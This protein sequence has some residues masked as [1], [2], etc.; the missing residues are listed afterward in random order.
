MYSKSIEPAPP[1]APLSLAA[2][3][4]LIYSTSAYLML[5]G[6]SAMLYAIIAE[7]IERDDAYLL[8]DKIARIEMLLLR[9]D[10]ELLEQEVAWK[11]GVEKMP[12]YSR[13]V[14]R[15]GRLDM[16]TASMAETLPYR[17]FPPPVPEGA[18]ARVTTVQHSKLD[19]G[20]SFGMLSATWRNPLTGDSGL[21]QVGLDDT[22]EDLY[23]A[24]VRAACFLV[25]LFGTLLSAGL[26]HLAARRGLK[27]LRDIAVAAER[28][29]AS[30][31]NERIDPAH[32]PRE[33]GSLALALNRMLGR[34]E[35]AFVRMSQCTAELAHEL[36]TPIHNL[37]GE[38]GVA[39]SAKRK[40]EEYRRVLESSLEEYER[41]SRMINEM[42]F[43]ARAENP[44]QQL[45][46]ERFDARRELEAVREFFDALSEARG[47][48]VTC[49]GSAELEANALL[50]RRALTNLVSNALRHTP[51]GGEV[52]LAVDQPSDVEV[53]VKVSDSGQ[54]IAPEQA[55]RLWDRRYGR[56]R[57][58]S[59]GSNGLG[60]SIVKSIMELHG[61]AITLQS[62]P[63]RGTC[64]QLRFPQ[65]QPTAGAAP[66]TRCA[67]TSLQKL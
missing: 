65:R 60:L 25:L 56:A 23:L 44:K 8:V 14:D 32:W 38:A 24:R 15:E 48:R 43:L 58:A 12:F 37:M 30:Q 54:G 7:G 17:R 2:R 36:R 66:T 59:P 3:L 5:V 41:L 63:G 29:T 61:G 50:F 28:I 31:L 49:R 39:L 64:V 51:R 19:D 42:L 10:R 13:V 67:L 11:G 4:F 20:R 46:R 16:E 33:L 6:A 57:K 1:R 52:V 18:L 9:G 26:G 22:D 40:P 47:I 62:A 34:L 35:E 27:P 21:I 53:L 45:A 55:P